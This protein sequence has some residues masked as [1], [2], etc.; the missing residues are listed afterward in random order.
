MRFGKFYARNKMLMF[1]TLVSGLFGMGLWLKFQGAS[2]HSKIIFQ[3]TKEWDLGPVLDVIA[4]SGPCKDGTEPKRPVFQGTRTY[5][6]QG[7]PNKYTMGAC[8]KNR[9]SWSTVYGLG[10]RV[11]TSMNG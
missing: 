3:E 8:A 5:C 10:S 11:M 2:Q 6:Y 1:L 7:A 9:D 4:S